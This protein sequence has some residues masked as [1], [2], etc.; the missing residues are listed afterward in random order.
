MQAPSSL[1]TLPVTS[2]VVDAYSGGMSFKANLDFNSGRWS[3]TVDPPEGDFPFVAHLGGKRYELY[4][5]ET[6][7]EVER[8]PNPID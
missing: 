2:A 5:D 4:S 8:G 3:A 6:F 1:V 7:A